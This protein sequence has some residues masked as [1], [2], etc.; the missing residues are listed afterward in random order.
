MLYGRGGRLGGAGLAVLYV[1]G[2]RVGGVGLA[3]L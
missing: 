1:R 3:M 2:A